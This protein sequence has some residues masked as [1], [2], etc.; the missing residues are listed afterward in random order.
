MNGRSKTSRLA[1]MVAATLL[2]LAL[3]ACYQ[4]VPVSLN[5]VQPSERVRISLS[6]S[7]AAELGDVVGIRQHA[8]SARLSSRSPTSVSLIVPSAYAMDGT[9]RR[10]LYQQV[11]LAPGDV[12]SVQR[13]QL[14]RGRTGMLAASA[15]LATVAIAM[16][17]F[18]GESGGGPLEP[19]GPSAEALHPF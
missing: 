16:K 7:A 9:S 8:V 1:H 4:H 15:A 10:D 2:M 3:P 18:G 6:P 12:L 13:V 17:I 5:Y 19:G 11:H 14:N